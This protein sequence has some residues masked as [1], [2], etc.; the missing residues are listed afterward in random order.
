MSTIARTASGKELALVEFYRQLRSDG[1]PSATV[2]AQRAGVGR[3]HL[4]RLL[5]GGSA[6][7]QTGRYT[8]KHVLPVLSPA[9]LCALKQC[10]AWNIHAERELAH[11]E[12]ARAWVASFLSEPFSP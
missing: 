4:A 12:R 3:A 5:G 1:I 2:L 6:G 7:R 10:S 11:L 8:W 9:A